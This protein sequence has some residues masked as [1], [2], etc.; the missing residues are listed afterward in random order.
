MRIH[1]VTNLALNN[2]TIQKSYG[3]HPG[4]NKPIQPVFG[5]KISFKGADVNKNQILLL[6][7]GCTSYCV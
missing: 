3:T 4:T 6:E 2:K 1:S 7:A 5:T